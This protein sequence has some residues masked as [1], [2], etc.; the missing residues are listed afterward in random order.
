MESSEHCL[1]KVKSSL[2]ESA[3]F[4]LIACPASASFFLGTRHPWSAPRPCVHTH[5]DHR[6][7]AQALARRSCLPKSHLR[8]AKKLPAP[9]SYLVGMDFVPTCQNGQRFGLLQGFQNHLRLQSVVDLA[10][11]PLGGVAIAVRG[12]RGGLRL[13]LPVHVGLL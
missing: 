9:L 3:I 7:R 5:R 1:F 4:A 8:V 11:G 12:H 13:L 6:E 2:V 10:A